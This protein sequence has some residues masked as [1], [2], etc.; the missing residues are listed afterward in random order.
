VIYYSEDPDKNLNK[1][2]RIGRL[3]PSPGLYSDGS[4]SNEKTVFGQVDSI[5]FNQIDDV[6]NRRVDIVTVW[7]AEDGSSSTEIL[8]NC[9]NPIPLY[10]IDNQLEE[11]TKIETEDIRQGDKIFAHIVN[12]KL[13]CAVVVRD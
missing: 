3:R 13:R 8:L 1:I 5:Q 11:I 6:L 9:R 2:Q 12:Y 4:A 10:L 7:T